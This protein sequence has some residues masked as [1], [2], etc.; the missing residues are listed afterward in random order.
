[1]GGRTEGEVGVRSRRDGGDQRDVK[2]GGGPEP[3]ERRGPGGRNRV[4]PEG[5]EGPGDVTTRTPG[6]SPCGK[7][8]TD[9]ESGGVLAVQGRDT[10]PGRQDLP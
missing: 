1:M 10:D 9:G 4:V 6:T 8:E 5:S 3:V 7:G 2:T